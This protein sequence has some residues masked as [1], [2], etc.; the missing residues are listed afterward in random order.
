MN[1]HDVS[2]PLI[3]RFYNDMW[4]RFDTSVFP[5]I[6]QPGITFRGSLGQT[7]VGVEQLADYIACET[8]S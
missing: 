8:R 7:T 1:R 2:R 3:D 6:L 4:N 5:E